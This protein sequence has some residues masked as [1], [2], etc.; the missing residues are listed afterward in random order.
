VQNNIWPTWGR[1]FIGLQIGLEKHIPI[2]KN[3]QVFGDVK[4]VFER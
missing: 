3:N 2:I 1:D 4:S